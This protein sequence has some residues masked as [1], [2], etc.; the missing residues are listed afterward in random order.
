MKL[1]NYKNWMIFY[2]RHSWILWLKNEFFIIFHFRNLHKNWFDKILTI[3]IK[4]EFN[5][6]FNS[7]RNKWLIW[8]KMTVLLFDNSVEFSWNDSISCFINYSIS[9]IFSQWL[10]ELDCSSIL[11]LMK[12][13]LCLFE[14][15]DSRLWIIISIHSNSEISK[16]FHL[17]LSI[18]K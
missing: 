16:I 5:Y 11:W 8:K 12:L 3:H 6:Q 1:E 4:L 2:L 10:I 7:K 15:F 9:N 13:L 17:N 14:D 18:I